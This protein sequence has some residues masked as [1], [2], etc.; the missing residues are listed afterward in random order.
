MLIENPETFQ[1]APLKPKGED[2]PVYYLFHVPKCAGRTIDRH[3]SLYAQEGRYFRAKKRRGIGRL[4]SPRHTLAGMP[5]PRQLNA[6]G[7]HYLGASME[8]ICEGREIRRALLLRDPVSHMVSYYNFR[9]QRYIA[10]GMQPYSFELAYR[11]TQRD[12]ITHYIL[13]NFLE[14]PLPRLWLMTRPQKWTLVNEFLSRFWFVGDYR[15]CSE[16]ISAMAPDLGVPARAVPQNTCTGHSNHPTWRPLSVADLSPELIRR[17]REENSLDQRLWQTW[18]G[19]GLDVQSVNETALMA[20]AKLQF[21]V[22]EA[23]RLVYQVRRRVARRW[24]MPE[25]PVPA[26]EPAPVQAQPVS[27]AV[28]AG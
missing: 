8:R 20:P 11:A 12:F 9:M 7:S 13:R 16:L 14:I 19:A 2:A 27:R 26:P 1:G 6:V 22:Q 3:L 10:Q 21:S 17:I 15:K 28:Q 24:N 5:D 25:Q 4:F 18:R 23:A